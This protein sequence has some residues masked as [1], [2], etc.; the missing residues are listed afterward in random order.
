MNRSKEENKEKAD[1][2]SPHSC[3][4]LVGYSATV[5]LTCGSQTEG[6]SWPGGRWQSDSFGSRE[7]AGVGIWAVGPGLQ[8]GKLFRYFWGHSGLGGQEIRGGS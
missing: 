5:Q 8:E 3:T 6:F 2:V 1:G 7:P 4:G